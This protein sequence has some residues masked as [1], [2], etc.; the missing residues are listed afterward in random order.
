VHQQIWNAVWTTA[1]GS[2]GL[3][4]AAKGPPPEPPAG[5]PLET[6]LQSLANL[7]R[8][9]LEHLPF[10]AGGVLLLLLTWSIANLGSHLVARVFQRSKLRT[11][12][13][14][15]FRQLTSLAIWL[16][17]ITVACIVMF[18]DLFPMVQ[19][20]ANPDCSVCKRLECTRLPGTRCL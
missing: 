1:I 2:T 12:L 4:A 16:T 18:P 10:L 7:W 6:I 5:S 9:L 11:S 3:G 20:D 17:G 13:K 8:D 14:D 15:L 19:F